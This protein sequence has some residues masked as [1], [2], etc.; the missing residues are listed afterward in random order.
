MFT[1]LVYKRF[2]AHSLNSFRIWVEVFFSENHSKETKPFRYE[3]LYIVNVTKLDN[4]LKYFW[5]KIGKFLDKVKTGG[6]G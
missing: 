3:V 5:I 2:L 6:S 4:M 1:V